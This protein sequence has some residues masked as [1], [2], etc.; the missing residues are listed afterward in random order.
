HRRAHTV[1]A[2]RLAAALITT[3]KRHVIGVIALLTSLYHFIAA[4]GE[5]A[6]ES[7]GVAIVP[8]VDFAIGPTA[9]RSLFAR[10]P[11]AF[12]ESGDDAVAAFCRLATKASDRAR[13]AGL[14]LTC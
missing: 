13:P 2:I 1:G 6:H 8:L 10:L 12:F 3:V 11:L 9:F 7:H 4:I 5:C 14:Q